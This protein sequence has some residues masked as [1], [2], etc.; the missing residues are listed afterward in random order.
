MNVPEFLASSLLP[1]PVQ[2]ADASIAVLHCSRTHREN[3]ASD[4]AHDLCKPVL[5][6]DSACLWREIYGKA[7]TLANDEP[8]LLRRLQHLVLQRN[9][10]AEVLCAILAR[11]LASSDMPEEELFALMIEIVRDDERL[12]GQVRADL[13]A[14]KTRDPAC[15]D[16]LHVLLN[17]KGFQALQVHRI[18][19]RLWGRQRKE[20]AFTLANAASRIFGADIHPAA[21]IGCGVML[22]HGTGIVIGET[23]VVEDNVSILQEVTLG[24]TGKEC[25]DRHPKIR[26]GVLLGAGAKV[27]GNIEIGTM[28]KIAAGSV[29]LKPVPPHSTVAGV[30]A[31]IVRHHCVNDAPALEMQQTI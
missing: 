15:P 5:V 6:Q 4:Q 16:H 12:M 3:A 14:V 27:L 19:H 7:L 25:G 28:S 26:S 2:H 23:A 21:V 17:L 24:G 30:P 31:R 29:V 13:N 1:R 11:Q 9:S 20:L 8:M 18:A 22:D 10:L